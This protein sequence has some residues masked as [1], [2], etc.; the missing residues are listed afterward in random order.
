M[1]FDNPALYN[2]DEIDDVGEDQIN[3]SSPVKF[4]HF[5]SEK[6]LFAVPLKEGYLMVLS[7]HTLKPIKKNFIKLNLSPVILSN[8]F[9]SN[10]STHLL[11]SK[12]HILKIDPKIVLTRKFLDTRTK[13]EVENNFMPLSDEDVEEKNYACKMDNSHLT[14][15]A[16]KI[17]KIIKKERIE[18][19]FIRS[20]IPFI[21]YFNSFFT[22]SRIKLLKPSIYKKMEELL[23]RLC[24]F[25]FK[26]PYSQFVNIFDFDGE[27]D[28]CRQIMYKEMNILDYMN[29]LIGKP[30]ERGLFD[31]KLLKENM[32]I[33]RV[34]SIAQTTV[35]YILKDN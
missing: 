28:Y 32:P 5:L 17:I 2:K 14:E 4:K 3:K 13:N 22:G 6:Y 12:E 26:T 8:N 9:I 30:F 11:T 34:L 19:L 29:D 31:I 25:L 15:N 24:C 7:N 18:F 21:L 35:K 10:N 1:D 23:I 20:S 27:P 33:S 16:F